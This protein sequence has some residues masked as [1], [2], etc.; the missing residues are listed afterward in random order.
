MDLD[1][2]DL[3]LT[4]YVGLSPTKLPFVLA[5]GRLSA[6]VALTFR[7][8]GK[9]E[10]GAAVPQSFGIGGHVALASLAIADGRGRT[11]IAAKSVDVDIAKIDP[12][13]GVVAL[14]TVA[15]VEPSIDATRRADGSIDLVDL[16]RMP[17]PATTVARAPDAGPK[18]AATPPSTPQVTV[19]D[20][21]IERGRVRI[22]DEAVAPAATIVLTGIDVDAG[23]VALAG[24]TPTT[25]HVALATDDGTTLDAKGSVVVERRDANG[26]IELKGFRPARVAPY[27]AS[28]VAA[29]IDDGS[30][31]AARAL[32]RRRVED[33][34]DRPRRRH[35]AARVAPANERGR[36][37]RRRVRAARRRRCDRARRRRVRP[38]DARV[39]G[40]TADADRADDR[41]PSRRE[42]S[43]QP[44]GRDRRGEA[45]RDAHGRRAR[46]R[47]EAGRGEAVHRRRQGAR[48]R[49]RRRVDRRRVGA[50]AGPRPACSR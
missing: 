34:R 12:F 46:G 11:A 38:R 18:T 42:G 2:R 8:A 9:D 26:T 33:R 24:A 41:D 20:A 23:A 31:D 14:R 30:V 13:N 4:E 49:A 7:A 40:R 17:G 25:F 37:A 36:H 21:R 6:Q 5:S 44:A 50:D 47:G 32:P 16:F 35:R 27:L 28:S 3:D 1:L 29:R 19:A 15:V 10:A 48:D 45:R 22:V 39:H 43:A